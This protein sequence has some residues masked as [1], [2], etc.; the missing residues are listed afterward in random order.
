[1]CEETPPTRS[2][3]EPRLTLTLSQGGSSISRIYNFSLNPK[4]I[5]NWMKIFDQC[6]GFN[7]EDIRAALEQWQ[8]KFLNDLGGKTD[9]TLN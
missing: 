8:W 1:M 4:E 2:P 5:V 9:E 6:L 3:K 7:P